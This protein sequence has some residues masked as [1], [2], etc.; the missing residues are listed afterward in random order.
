MQALAGAT[1]ALTAYNAYQGMQNP[2]TSGGGVGI[3]ITVGGSKSKDTSSVTTDTAAASTVAAGG[4]VTIRAS[5]AGEQSDITVQGSQISAGRDL[6]L[7]AEDDINLLAAANTASVERSSKSS[8]AGVG[9]AITYGSD[10]F[11]FGITANASAAR[12]NA[13]GDDLIWSNTHL[14]AGETLTLRSGD[15]TTLKAAVASGERVVADVGGDLSIESLQ[16]IS[17]FESRDKS[18]GGSVT[19]GYGFAGSVQ[20]GQAKIDSDFASVA[21]QS[22]LRAGDGGFDVRVGGDTTLTGGAITSTDAAVDGGL[23]HFETGGEL[24][25]VDIHNRAEYEASSYSVGFGGG[26]AG[27]GSNTLGGTNLMS[28]NA[29]PT[30]SAG[31]GSDSDKA[32]STTLAAISGIAGNSGARTGDAET[33]LA[34]IFDADKVKREMD[35]QV[36][37]TQA[38]GQH[39]A[40]AWGEYANRKFA[41]AIASADEEGMQCWAP[42]GA[43][44][45]GGHAVLGGLTGGM[46]GALGAGLSSLTA[47]HL[48][49]F[50]IEQGLPPGAAQAITQL[51]AL[52]AGTAAGGPQSGAAAM[53]EASNNA[54]QAAAVWPLIAEAVAAG[55]AA[56]ARACLSSPVC[57]NAL[58][59][60]GTSAVAWVAS[61]LSEE[62]LAQIPGFGA[63]HQ[64][65]PFGPLTT[66]IP[67]P[68]SLQRMYGPPPLENQEALT[69]WL[70]NA[71]QGYPAHQAEQ[72][73]KDFIHTLPMADQLHYSD[74]IIMAAK[75]AAGRTSL[76][77][78]PE[79]KTL[80]DTLGAHTFNIPVEIWNGMSERNVGQLTKNFLI[81]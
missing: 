17:T 48:Q 30:G 37:I 44:R 15:D 77:H 35:A 24:A 59:M 52:G 38:F 43:C 26:V 69:A 13:E 32:S 78:Y 49:A 4:D 51:T 14:S 63:G 74:L 20:V 42:D 71:L 5:G 46:E 9:V 45:A 22:A 18:A 60:A 3:S 72:W 2:N 76:G 1:T 56:S 68:D 34:P 36:A 57:V 50:L 23:N 81:A 6:T 79:Y 62:E 80:G 31:V 66:P 10:G 25:L 19:I 58:K 28:V 61:L 11:A 7:I 8:S 39:S 12:G 53:N 29:S 73:A 55:G 54:V 64:P 41:D 21:E 40:K 75:D 67:D 65:P 27:S 47:P 33:G 16:D 70:A